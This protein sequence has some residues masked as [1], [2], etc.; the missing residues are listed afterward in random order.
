MALFR[1][2][3]DKILVCSL[4][5]PT[6]SLIAQAPGKG[7]AFCALK[8][9]FIVATN[10]DS[11]AYNYTRWDKGTKASVR[12]DGL[13]GNRALTPSEYL[14]A[15]EGFEPDILV[16]LSDEVPAEATDSRL[17]TSVEKSLRWAVSSSNDDICSA[18]LYHFSL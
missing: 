9:K 18:V 14:A 1:H 3:I 7:R 13:A 15:A 11:F 10:R 12:V 8:N 5:S 6:P 4:G 17:Q 2:V 16:P